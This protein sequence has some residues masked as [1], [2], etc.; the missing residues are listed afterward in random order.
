MID[1]QNRQNTYDPIKMVDR[2]TRSFKLGHEI[3][4]A[5]GSSIDF[6]IYSVREDYATNRSQSLRRSG[7]LTTLAVFPTPVSRHS[8]SRVSFRFHHEVT[9]YIADIGSS[10]AYRSD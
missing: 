9:E 7:F 4:H 1:R 6:E 2:R 5:N 8:G 3:L 10:I